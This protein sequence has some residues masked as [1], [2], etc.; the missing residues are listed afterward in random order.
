MKNILFII[1]SL[2]MMQCSVAQKTT[3]QGNGLEELVP[4][5]MT[6]PNAIDTNQDEA[7]SIEEVMAAPQQL[8]TLDKNGDGDLDWKEIG[9]WEKQLP[10]VRDHNIINLID[11][12]GDIHISAEEIKNA[13][14]ELKR[15]D[16]NGDWTISKKELFFNKNPNFPPFTNKKMPYKMW[17][18]FR[19]YTTNNEGPKMPGQD[20][21]AFKGYTLIHD[22]GDA[23]MGQQSN[24]TYLMDENGIRVHEWKH[25]GYSPE[26]SVAYLLPNGQLLRTF[27][28]HHWIKD[29]AFP[30]GATSSIELVDWDGKVLWD[31]TQSV[32]EKYSFH[33]DVEY[34]PNGNILAIRY[35]A[36]SLE[37]AIAM[38]WDANL[39]KKAIYS[40]KNNVAHKPIIWMSNVLE[41]QPNLEDG[42][43]EIV[44]QWNSWDHLV[45]NKYP[46][47]NNYGA[48]TDPSKIHINYLNL[49]VDIPYN[50][51]QFFHLNSV[52]YNPKLDLIMLSSPTYGEFWIIDHSISM[53]EASGSTGGKYGKGGDLLYRWGN[54]ET[55]GK[56]IR[57]E[58]T[59]YWQHD[60]QWIDE[61]LPGAGNV[62]IYN[63]GQ[64]RSLDGK[65]RRN[66]KTASFGKS[67]SNVLEVKLPMSEDG[68]FD[69]N[70]K[71]NIVWDWSHPDKTSYYSP[72]MSGA[73]RLPNGNT[74][75]NGAYDK[76]IHEVNSDG[77]ILLDYSLEGWGRLYRVYKYGA[78]YSGL[79]FKN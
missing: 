71:A 11:A 48:A 74:I 68:Q 49:D 60:T 62:L 72:F 69:I 64:R 21:R 43:T 44:W 63:N 6:V 75:F 12:N 33:H 50:R 73:T 16:L 41:L 79:K 10:L 51:G 66:D 25:N 9:A 37:E 35:N 29:K 27:S 76:Y 47:K 1:C 54:D 34:L 56:G 61:G 18:K 14:K 5:L 24:D 17:R 23:F 57:D 8:A 39:G 22:A 36:F 31:F 30:V 55:Y 7:L 26:A 52:D 3:L 70:K 67:Y 28:K 40:I 59:L 38:G 77:E 20:K 2:S 4:Q 53:A 46:S 15:L 13:P 78:D 58:S 65:Y 45:Q 42:S 19:G 32:P